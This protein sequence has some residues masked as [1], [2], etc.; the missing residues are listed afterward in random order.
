MILQ[1]NKPL[2][3]VQKI[4]GVIHQLDDRPVYYGSRM[5]KND[6]CASAVD[7]VGIVLPPSDLKNFR[8]LLSEWKKD[9]PDQPLIVLS[10]GKEVDQNNRNGYSDPMSQEVTS[11]VL[12]PIL[13][14]TQRSKRCRQFYSGSCRLAR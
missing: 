11:P 7:F 1:M 3:F 13:C 5:L 9:H 4:A 14:S 6:V 2:G 12:S 10:Y 8:R